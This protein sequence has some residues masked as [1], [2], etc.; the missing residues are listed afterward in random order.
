MR[1]PACFVIRRSLAISPA[2]AATAASKSTT[3]TKAAEAATTAT[4]AAKTPATS[5]PSPSPATKPARGDDDRKA[6]RTASS[7]TATST[8]PAEKAKYYEED[9]KEYPRRNSTAA[10]GR[11]VVARR[12]HLR[13][14]ERRVQLEV[15][16]LRESL[17]GSQRHELEPR[18]IVLL[19]E[20][21]R[22]FTAD[23]ACIRIRDE[24]FR[25]TARRDE[26][27]SASIPARLLGDEKDHCAGVAGGIAGIPDLADLPLPSDQERGL[28]HVAR[29][30]VGKRDD[31][32]L[33]PRFR[34]HILRDALHSLS[35]VG[36]NHVREVIHQPDRRRD[37]EALRKEEEPGCSQNGENGRR[38]WK[39]DQN[40]SKYLLSLDFMVWLEVYLADDSRPSQPHPCA[41]RARAFTRLRPRRQQPTERRNHDSSAS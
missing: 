33:P 8:R 32:H 29:A 35:G 11:V 24:S 4:K 17:S 26:A 22:G 16:L 12:R 1:E 25:A 34:A 15:E 7:P 10:T 3:A 18:T 37:L 13:R 30:D 5:A 27:M 23:V 14:C 40:R 38:R 31:R 6:S 20:G 41:Q 21:R 28:L 19:H 36:R 39:P 9:E 2:R